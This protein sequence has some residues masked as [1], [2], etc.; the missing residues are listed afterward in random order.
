MT[1][2]VNSPLRSKSGFQSPSF[3]VDA[4][5]N[6]TARSITLAEEDEITTV[7]AD[8]SFEES[9]GNFRLV[10]NV[11]NNPQIT[12]YRNTPQT[13]DLN[14]TT[15][16]LSIFS[17]V[18]S[19]LTLYN[20]GIRHSDSTTGVDAQG[21]STGRLYF[22]PP[23]SAPNTLYYGNATGT[24]YGIINVVDPTG[25]FSTVDITSSIVSTSSTT[26]ALTVAG[27]V[28][29]AGDLYIGGSLNIDGIGITSISSPT[30]LNFEAANNIIVKIDG[31]TLGT[32]S[33]SG[34]SVPVVN[35]TINNTVIGGVTPAA[36]AFTSATVTSLPTIDSSV[37]NRQYVDSTALSLAIAFGL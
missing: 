5:G 32:I 23:V 1:T 13:I 24:I 35:S 17:S 12:I 28:G 10:G 27:G 16:T 31:S 30:N 8:F 19:T 25:L 29:I 14:F 9:A 22:S 18:G 4:L 37:T 33:A 11:S 3:S 20:N 15:I 36:A 6:I 21:K 7:A 2:I 34:S 26:G